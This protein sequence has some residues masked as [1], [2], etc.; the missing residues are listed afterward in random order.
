[1]SFR[2]FIQRDILPKCNDSYEVVRL[3]SIIILNII[4]FPS[5][6]KY[7]NIR[8]VK[9]TSINGYDKDL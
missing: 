9:I 5:D 4:T 1:M 6:N 3:L 2:R 7:K 8:M